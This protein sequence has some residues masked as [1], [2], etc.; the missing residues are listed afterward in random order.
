[1]SDLSSYLAM[2]LDYTSANVF[3]F[4]CVETIRVRKS[5]LYADFIKKQ[6]SHFQLPIL[7]TSVIEQKVEVH[8]SDFMLV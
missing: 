5:C 6:I 3:S 8:K 7:S 1:M 2:P 4:L